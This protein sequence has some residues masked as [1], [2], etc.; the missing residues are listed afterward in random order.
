MNDEQKPYGIKIGPVG[1]H[2]KARILKY[3]RGQS[4]ETGPIPGFSKPTHHWDA[5]MRDVV[6]LPYPLAFEEEKARVTNDRYE[7][8]EI[9]VA[10]IE[11]HLKLE[12]NDGR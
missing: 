8:L 4:I 7:L 6:A 2:G 11:R 5:D 10:E 9:R 12:T 1:S 3:G